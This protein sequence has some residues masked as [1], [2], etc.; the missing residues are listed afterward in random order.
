[1]EVIKK[2]DNHIMEYYKSNN[3]ITIYYNYNNNLQCI[4]LMYNIKEKYFFGCDNAIENIMTKRQIK[5]FI[6]Q[7][8]NII[9]K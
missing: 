8:E 3:I 5:I 9:K 1:M 2:I 7:L 6:K 4:K